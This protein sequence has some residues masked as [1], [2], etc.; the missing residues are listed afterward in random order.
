LTLWVD[1]RPH[2]GAIGYRGRHGA[3]D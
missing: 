1:R 3:R 2:N